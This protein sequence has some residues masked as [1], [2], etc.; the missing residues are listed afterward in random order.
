MANSCT[1]YQLELFVLHVLFV[2]SKVTSLMATCLGFA[3][4]FN[5]LW[6]A[7]KLLAVVFAYCF[8]V[9]IVYCENLVFF[10]AST[11]LMYFRQSHPFHSFVDAGSRGVLIAI[12]IEGCAKFSSMCCLGTAFF[13]LPFFL[14]LSRC[15]WTS[16]N[17]VNQLSVFLLSVQST[18]GQ[19]NQVKPSLPWKI[20]P[21]MGVPKRLGFSSFSWHQY[22]F[23]KWGHEPSNLEP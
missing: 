2:F 1:N 9:H 12:A 21:W 20:F 16:T 14:S 3:P 13:G 23:Q 18:W 11:R 22:F 7:K 17:R 6:L 8:R 15:E 5:K 10:I 4:F 19:V